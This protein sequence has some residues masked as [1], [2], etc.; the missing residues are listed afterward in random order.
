MNIQFENPEKVSGVLTI[1]LEKE[2]YQ[3]EVEK[4]LKDYR[5]RA[6]VPGFRIGQVPMGMIKR[7]YGAAVKL[8]VVNKMLND[9][10]FEY[11]REN[12]IKML[13][14]PLA[15]EKQ[16]PVDIEKE[17]TLTFMFDIAITPEFKA[18]LNG[19]DKIDYYT[20]EVDDKIIDQQID[21]YRSRAGH[22][23]KAQKY[24]ETKNDMLHGD[25]R[26]LDAE[27]NTKEGGIAVENVMLMPEY[28]KVDDQKKLFDGCKLG[29][30]ITFNPRKAYP[31]NDTEVSSML[32]IEKEQV[33]EHTGDFTYQITEVSR[34]EKAEVNQELFDSVFGKDAVTDEKSFR[35]KVAA[36]LRAQ[37]VPEQDFKFLRDVRAHMEKKVGKLQYAD[38]LMK[39]IMLQNNQEKGEKYVE[40]NYEGSINELTW[41]L[42]RDELVA[43]NGIK[44]DDADV[45]NVAREAA[46]VQFAQ[47][48]MSNVPDEYLDNYADSMMKKGE[49]VDNLVDRAIDTKLTEALKK[50][51]KLNEK[52][53]TL[54]EFNKMMQ[55]K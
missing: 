44:I 45:K 41:R 55:A 46:R 7:Q 28:I 8:D 11:V 52:S 42:I 38:S 22:Y 20:I 43:A 25:L 13:G 30:I 18:E 14:Q 40:D 53:V 31:D 15:N 49:N 39:R 6:N 47:Y 9:K 4:T 50:V 19:K 33:A 2:D 12:N 10:L 34:F 48:G 54:D 1:T 37:F 17:D 21:M 32:K 29:D 26:E 23:E 27:G 35:E 36:E 51:V 24:D 5:K 3:P 16:T